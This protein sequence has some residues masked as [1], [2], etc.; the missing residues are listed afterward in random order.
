MGEPSSPTLSSSSLIAPSKTTAAMVVSWTTP[1][2]T[3][4][5]AHSCSSPSTHTRAERE[6]ANL[7]RPKVRVRSSPSR[8]SAETPRVLSSELPS[9][10]DQS[11]LPSRPT[12]SP[13]R[14]TPA[15]SSPTDAEPTST[16]VSSP[17]ATEPR[18]AKSTSSSRTPG[19]PHGVTTVMS[20]SHQTSAVSPTSHPTQP[21]EHD[22]IQFTSF[23]QYQLL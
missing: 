21:A 9:T 6:L 10:R 23:V 3:L 19:A 8:T 14:A 1:S 11:P 5:P 22:V 2:S 20:R 7:S 17:S 12:S 13:S 4:S 16:T 15:V 18:A